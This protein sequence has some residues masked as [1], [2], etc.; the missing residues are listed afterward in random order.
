MA[1]MNK[2]HTERERER[3]HEAREFLKNMK[4]S[5]TSCFGKTRVENTTYTQKHSQEEYWKKG[6]RNDE[7]EVK[8]DSFM[9]SIY[10][11]LLC[12]ADDLSVM[13]PRR[14]QK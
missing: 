13:D 10:L 6:K 7:H 3:K 14:T 11:C 1:E 9:C 4:M 8:S 5:K 2:R 12:F